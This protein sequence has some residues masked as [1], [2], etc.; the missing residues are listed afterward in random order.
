MCSFLFRG[1]WPMFVA[2]TFL[3]AV[4]LPNLTVWSRSVYHWVSRLFT[5]GF[6]FITF[7]RDNPTQNDDASSHH[8]LNWEPKWIRFE[9]GTIRSRKKT[10]DSSWTR[11]VFEPSPK[12]PS[13]SHWHPNRVQVLKNKDSSPTPLII[14]SEVILR[15]E[16]W[17]GRL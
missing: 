7:Q 4:S 12:C 13:P 1:N 15:T 11:A 16:W 2:R 17:I 14:C 3:S 5:T 6:G 9:I 8:L 10:V